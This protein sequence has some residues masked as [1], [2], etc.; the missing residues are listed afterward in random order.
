MYTNIDT[1]HALLVIFN[2]LRYSRHCRGVAA[3]PIICALEFI[4]RNNLC[5]FGDTYWLEITGT[6]MGTLPA[7][8][9]AILY[10]GIHELEFSPRFQARVLF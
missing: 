6:A 2:F 9:Y 8:T 1:T 10:Y 3:E 7:C 4:M 5:K